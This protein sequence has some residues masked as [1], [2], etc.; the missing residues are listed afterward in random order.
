MYVTWVTGAAKLSASPPQPPP[1]NLTSQVIPRYF[2]HVVIFELKKP[3]QCIL[4][5]GMFCLLDFADRLHQHNQRFAENRN[6]D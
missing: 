2:E 6:P 4:D 1:A 3:C 5:A